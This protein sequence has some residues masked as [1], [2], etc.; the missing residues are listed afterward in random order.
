MDLICNHDMAQSDVKDIFNHWLKSTE[1][2][3]FYAAHFLN[4]YYSIGH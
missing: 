3:M 4:Q 1:C 2:R